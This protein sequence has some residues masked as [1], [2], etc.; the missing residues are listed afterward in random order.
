MSAVSSLALF[1]SKNLRT[2]TNRRRGVL[3]QIYWEP[4]LVDVCEALVHFAKLKAW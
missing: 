2:D 3:A 4:R 1:D